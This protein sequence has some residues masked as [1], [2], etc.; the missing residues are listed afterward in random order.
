MKLF[1]K[2]SILGW[3]LLI[4]LIALGAR[5]GDNTLIIGDENPAIDKEIQIGD[6]RLKWDAGT[7]KT[8]FSNNAGVSFVDIGSGAGG[9][10]GQNFFVN[11]SFN[12]ESGTLG[13]NVIGSAVISTTA[14]TPINGDFSLTCDMDAQN[15]ICRSDLIPIPEKFKGQACEVNFTYTGITDDLV[16]PQVVDS[17]NVKLPGATYQNQVDGT[18]FLQAQTG[19]VQRSIF[20]ICPSSGDIK[21]EFNQTVAGDP[22]IF[23]F[24]DVHVGELIGLQTTSIDADWSDCGFVPG[25]FSAGWGTVSEIQIQCRRDGP[26]ELMQGSFRTGSVVGSIGSIDLPSA[27]TIDLTKKPSGSTGRLGTIIRITTTGIFVASENTGVLFTDGADNDTIFLS[28]QGVSTTAFAK[29]NV[30]NHIGSNE[31]A[32]FNIRIPVVENAATP[33]KIFLSIPKVAENINE[34]SANV[35]NGG[36]ST[37]TS[38]NT[39][40]INGDCTRTSIGFVQ[41]TVQTNLNLT[42]GMSCTCTP[43]NTGSAKDRNCVIDS[44]STTNVDIRTSVASSGANADIDFS[45]ACQKQAAD[46]KTPVVQP[47]LVNQVTTPEANGIVI[48]T[49]FV[50]GNDGTP[51]ADSNLCANWID[52]FTDSGVG[53]YIINLTSGIFS[54][55]PHC[56]GTSDVGTEMVAFTAV[57]TSTINVTGFNTN[58]STVDTDFYITCIGER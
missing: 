46:F 27:F 5:I 34:F 43:D 23:E 40:W 8:Q 32:T 58:G 20:L 29:I 55:I 12:G 28:T 35:S 19:I 14:V 4:S 57:T 45:I 56:V 47:I 41:C 37:V 18:D 53:L 15:A 30:S 10:G 31:T 9:A 11:K 7:N 3:I 52:S 2:F 21:L 48:T 50:G 1:N 54:D 25:D 49:C 17:S 24:D 13:W 42:L 16:K 51:S 39:D 22:A 6:G 38:E 44:T 26:D 36:S 33:V